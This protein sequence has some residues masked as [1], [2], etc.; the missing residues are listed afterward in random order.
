[1]K[2]TGEGSQA[3]SAANLAGPRKSFEQKVCAEVGR[4]G[5]GGG[6]ELTMAQGES[7]GCGRASTS[8]RVVVARSWTQHTHRHREH[9][10]K[11]GTAPAAALA[12]P[13]PLTSRDTVACGDIRSPTRQPRAPAPPHLSHAVPQQR[14]QGGWAAASQQRTGGV[15]PPP[16][17]IY[18]LRAAIH[19]AASGQGEDPW[20][21]SASGCVS[22]TE[23]AGP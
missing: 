9:T 10:Y 13:Q 6:L 12:A 5:L 1:M 18:S 17:P 19:G 22:G 20:P 21:A 16:S 8:A 4:M 3:A 15:R 14:Y 11:R 2:D 7:E 23:A